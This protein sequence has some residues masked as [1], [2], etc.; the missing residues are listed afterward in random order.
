MRKEILRVEKKYG[1]KTILKW[2]LLFSIILGLCFEA[3]ESWKNAC[4]R[5]Y[6][7][8][9]LNKSLNRTDQSMPRINQTESLIQYSGFGDLSETRRYAYLTLLAIKR[10][11]MQVVDE[12]LVSDSRYNN[13]SLEEN[14][15]WLAVANALLGQDDFEHWFALV[16]K[17]SPPG[18]VYLSCAKRMQVAGQIKVAEKCYREAINLL[19]D[20]VDIHRQFADFLVFYKKDM[21]EAVAEYEVIVSL[22][23]S[24][25]NIIGLAEHYR[26]AERPDDALRALQA[27][28]SNNSNQQDRVT[29]ERA[30]AIDAKGNSAQA[31][32][33][34]E[35]A[36]QI[37]PCSVWVLD[38]LANKYNQM[39]RIDDALSAAYMEIDCDP[40]WVWGY[41]R[42]TR[43]LLAHNRP[44]EAKEYLEKMLTMKIQGERIEFLTLVELGTVYVQMGYKDR[45]LQAFCQAQKINSWKERIDYISQ[46]IS[47]LGMC[48]K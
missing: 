20:R 42:L 7:M 17:L 13:K 9:L 31:L 14:V 22:E 4:Y 10:G 32:Q 8:I 28:P 2:M 36:H 37:Y 30:L 48:P 3:G 43:I 11:N 40:N 41:W 25:D 35:Q 18:Y 23:P 29:V 1:Y 34:L 44:A 26:L 15:A 16:G 38:S 24:V 21:S 27:I 39:G 33:I 45:A 6:F 46:E 5:N 47:Q 12:L 19:P